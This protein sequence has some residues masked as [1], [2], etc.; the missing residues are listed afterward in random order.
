P[1]LHAIVVADFPVQGRRGPGAGG[2]ADLESAG[3]GGVGVVTQEV[4]G[5]EPLGALAFQPQHGQIGIVAEEDRLR[6]AQG[7]GR[8]GGGQDGGQGRGKD[9]CQGNL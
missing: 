7:E 3:L 1:Q 9:G 2:N 8:G 4:Q 5:G 6:F